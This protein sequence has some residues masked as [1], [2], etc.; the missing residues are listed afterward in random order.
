MEV[1]V[2]SQVRQ[3]LKSS[4]ECLKTNF[5]QSQVQKAMDKLQVHRDKYMCMYYMYVYIINYELRLLTFHL[6][7]LVTYCDL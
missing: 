5:Y 6:L 4:C 2:E 1:T 3:D 7:Q